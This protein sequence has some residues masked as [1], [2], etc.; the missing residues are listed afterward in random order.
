[1]LSGDFTEKHEQAS[2]LLYVFL[3]VRQMRM[4]PLAIRHNPDKPKE[5]SD[6]RRREVRVAFN[7][8]TAKSFRVST[9]LTSVVARDAQPNVVTWKR[10]RRQQIRLLRVFRRRRRTRCRI[11][12]QLFERGNSPTRVQT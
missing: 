6:G 3:A 8:Q 5:S 12:R 11:L 10:Q 7:L 9:A 4:L 1:M 2:R